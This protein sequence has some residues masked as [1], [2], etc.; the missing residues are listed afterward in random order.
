[1]KIAEGY[2]VEL[3]YILKIEDGDVVESSTEEGP[4]QYL[5]GNGELPDRLET[6]L[7]GQEVG[8]KLELTLEPGEAFGE[9]DIDALTTV[10]RAEF[11]EGAELEPDQ[12][13][14]V[15]IEVEGSDE[16]GAFE[17]DMR[18]VEVNDES[19]VLDANHPLAGKTIT[20]TVEVREFHE[21]T[22]EEREERHVHGEQ[23][24]H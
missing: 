12:W 17:M 11:P 5:H 2:L 9:Y 23:C 16:E 21:A 4:M 3:D 18:V 15:G 19:V 6:A 24:D 14:E 8:A 7:A 13:I 10:P 22:D 20:Y 1:M